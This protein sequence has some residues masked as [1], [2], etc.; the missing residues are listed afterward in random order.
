MKTDMLL[1]NLKLL[2]DLLGYKVIE[3]ASESEPWEPNFT[4]KAEYNKK[5]LNELR[6]I[7][8]GLESKQQELLDTADLMQDKILEVIQKEGPTEFTNDLF[9][10]KLQKNTININFKE[11]DTIKC[12]INYVKELIKGIRKN[13]LLIK[14]RKE[15]PDIT[16]IKAKPKDFDVVVEKEFPEEN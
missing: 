8:S 3:K 16:D 1:E 15:F 6:E 9:I 2:A 4:A 7:L 12:S 14:L 5:N 10:T 11:V 13:N